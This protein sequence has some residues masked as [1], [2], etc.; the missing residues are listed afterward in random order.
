M[1]R[2]RSN[3]P[4]KSTPLSAKMSARRTVS[5]SFQLSM[6]FSCSSQ[7]VALIRKKRGMSSG[8]A[9]RVKSTISKVNLVRFSK[10]PPYSSVRLLETGE[11]KEW[12][13]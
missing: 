11:R 3:L 5:S 8:M 6:S 7:S 10:L 1:Q 13:R 4:I 12:R 9:L 2:C